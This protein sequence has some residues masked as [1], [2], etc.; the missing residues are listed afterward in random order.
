MQQPCNSSRLCRSTVPQTG[1]RADGH[2]GHTPLL[3]W[4]QKCLVW[5]QG[6]L[7]WGQECLCWGQG[8][9]I[10]GHG[11]EMGVK[12]A[13][14]WGKE[15]HDRALKCMGWDAGCLGWYQSGL[16]WA[17]KCIFQ[18]EL[19]TDHAT[20]TSQK[21]HKMYTAQHVQF[22]YNIVALQIIFPS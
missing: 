2:D 8:C 11:A 20:T 6:A 19:S 18:L 9:C 1:N 16:G 5:G 21:T 13:W 17:H 22:Q 10:S 12:G 14:V 15:C 3:S 4:G 7:D